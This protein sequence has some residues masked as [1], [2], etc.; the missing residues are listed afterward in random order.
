MLQK[1]AAQTLLVLLFAGCGA[2]TGI[3]EG[4]P[5][6]DPSS[7][8]ECPEL[9]WGLCEALPESILVSDE[10]G[11]EPSDVAFTGRYLV[12][13]HCPAFG[14]ENMAVYRLDGALVSRERSEG[15]W[16]P[17]IAWN[18]DL[19]VGL[20]AMEEGYQWLDGHGRPRSEFVRILTDRYVGRSDVAP[21][22]A[23][24][25][26]LY[27]ANHSDLYFRRLGPEPAVESGFVELEL[28]T[29]GQERSVPEHV[30]D[31]NGFIQSFVTTL[32]NEP[33]GDL[34]EVDDE[35]SISPVM[36][37]SEHVTLPEGTQRFA[38]GLA[39]LDGGVFMSYDT[40]SGP[41]DN[42]HS[43]WIIALAPGDSE[44]LLIGT[45]E[46]QAGS[47]LLTLYDRIIVA[48]RSMESTDQMSLAAYNPHDESPLTEPRQLTEV[49]STSP[50]MT[51]TSR[52]FAVVWQEWSDTIGRSG[53][54]ARLQI[55]D[56][57]VDD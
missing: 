51:S 41:P 54:Q 31:E 6:D 56:C 20:V 38:E 37:M 53:R 18:D 52:G 1:A 14:Q 46:T 15:L 22:P 43:Q 26:L 50:R 5:I 2:K 23:G 27:L 13:T 16:Y 19:N 17:R 30:L 47:A 48:S 55:F 28:L 40:A 34:Y 10:E 45:S 12:V 3:R 49:Y 39:E 21:T 29:A 11:H 25:L 24:F 32:R 7:I 44:P 4:P 8:A 36:T 33:E 42:L 57:C 35:L 9:S